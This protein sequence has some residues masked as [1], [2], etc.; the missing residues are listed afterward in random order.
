MNRRRSYLPIPCGNKW[1]FPGFTLVLIR[2]NLL[3]LLEHRGPL[4]EARESPPNLDPES[5]LIDL[6]QA[7]RLVAVAF[8]FLSL[9]G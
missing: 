4:S 7:E 1:S 2:L 8:G 9:C 5:N 6:V 3:A